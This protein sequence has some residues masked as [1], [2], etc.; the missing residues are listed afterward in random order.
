M[1]E[2]R[3]GSTGQRRAGG[4]RRR[5]K[6]GALER[7]RGYRPSGVAWAAGGLGLVT[8]VVTILV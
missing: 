5:P 1:A 2:H 3:T 8:F 7:L 6:A 4:A